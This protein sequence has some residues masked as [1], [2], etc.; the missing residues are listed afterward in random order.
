MKKLIIFL[1]I[2]F[3]I[4]IYAY[5]V[6]LNGI[7]YD[8]NK[9]AQTASVVSGWPKYSGDIIIPNNIEVESV[10][11][12]VTSF[13]QGAFSQCKELTSISIPSSIISISAYCFNGC[14]ALTTITLPKSINYIGMY[15]FQ[16]CTNLSSVNIT[17]FESWCKIEF[18]SYYSNPLIYA[19]HLYLNGQL[20]T[21][22]KVPD[23]I[24]I[25]DKLL[26]G[27]S[28]LTSIYI[29]RSVSEIKANAFEGC[30]NIDSLVFQN[31]LD[32]LIVEEGSLGDIN[33][34][35]LYL[36]RNLKRKAESS[37]IYM[38]FYNI[39]TLTNLTIGANV[40]Y[41]DPY[42]FEGCYKIE[43]LCLEDGEEELSIGDASRIYSPFSK[44]P[45]SKL[46]IGRNL[47]GMGLP[48]AVST[49][50][51]VT[52]GDKITSISRLSNCKGLSSISIP[53]SVKTI[54]N[55]TFQN[56]SLINIVLPNSVTEIG[57]SAF[58]NCISLKTVTLS[59]SLS[60]ISWSMFDGCESLTTISIPESVIEIGGWAFNNC[61]SLNNPVIPPKVSNI[62]IR[63]FYGCSSISSV[64]IP[65]SVKTI[66]GWAFRE[67]KNLREVILENGTDTL[68]FLGES[69]NNESFYNCP[70]TSVF[71]GRHIY[72]TRA[73]Y[74]RKSP[75]QLGT[76]KKAII[77]INMTPYDGN[78]FKNSSIDTV[79]ITNNVTKLDTEILQGW[80]GLKYVLIADETTSLDFGAGG[81]FKYCPLDSVY[82]GRSMTYSSESPFRYN[83]EGLKHLAF[84]N[85]V[86]EL[87][88][89]DFL[90]LIALTS[91]ELPHSLK[92]IGSQTFYGCK[93]LTS[94]TIPNSVTEI[95]KQAF[96]LCI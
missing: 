25:I 86:T 3:P 43:N 33:I 36:G 14:I 59:D 69:S 20:I 27:L 49:P 94:L 12:T 95:G 42:Y 24:S 85:F 87:G 96:D 82:L 2:F 37:K 80:S 11:Y 66:G 31:G 79:S 88:D 40:T 53:N 26:N 64:N 13:G 57:S 32:T 18:D 78:A 46:H 91:L 68:E 34:K 9:D 70:L 50:F 52:F 72:Y 84:G 10:N 15:A 45:I 67:C 7:F 23:G 55:G 44:C 89:V 56:T 83:R 58:S 93:G 90:G 92:K 28:D 1:L 17:D 63:A 21:S 5:D 71:I 4:S 75:F 39:P 19:H 35:N 48:F 62:G 6:E 61:S 41:F 54:E 60:T 77:D 22:F 38:P 30:D 65:S 29:P 8:L 51:T 76:I 81:N 73:N 47:A 74:S 16:N